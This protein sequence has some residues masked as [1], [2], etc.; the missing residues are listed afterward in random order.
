MLGVF[1]L[2]L[3][4]STSYVKI[5]DDR[6][7]IVSR[8]YGG[9]QLPQG[10]IIATDG[11]TG[12][13]AETIP[14][15]TFKVSLLYNVYNSVTTV[16]LV[17]VP[18]GYYGRIVARDGENLPEGQLM[19][20]AWPDKE[21]THYLDAQYFMTHHGQRGQQLSVLKPGTYPIN[22]ALFQVMIAYSTD[23]DDFYDE[24]GRT[25][26]RSG[27]D[28]SITRVPAGFVGVVRSSMQDTAK[29]CRTIT[30]SVDKDAPVVDK[31]KGSTDSLTAELVPQGCKGIWASALQPNDYFLNR[32]AYDVTLVD[33]RVQNLEF[34]GG[35]VRRFIDLKVGQD[36][37]FAQKER[38]VEVSVPEGAA[39]PAVNSKVEGWEVP[40]ELRVVV[41]I[42]PERAPIIVAA[43][44]G[45]KDVEK[46]IM[47]PSIRSQVRNV[48]GGMITTTVDG[49]TV[50]RQT[51]ILDLIE[52]REDLESTI[53]NLVAIDGRRAGAD[54]KEIK[55]G[56]P[57]IPPELLLARQREQLASQLLR[58]FQQEKLA[59]D[60][61]ITSEQ[62]KATAN[63][64]AIL[65]KAQIEVQTS[66]LYVT[67]RTNRGRADRKYAEEQAA[68]QKAQ[69]D[70][71]G[72]ERV[73]MLKAWDS[74]LQNPGIVEKLAGFHLPSTMVFG[75]GGLDG[76]AAQ[77]GN[78][79]LF[80]GPAKK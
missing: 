4:L 72:P 58:A 63:Q 3:V 17:R 11:E 33:T 59:Q 26:Q 44:G 67:E 51:R 1:V 32:E 25:Q 7:G 16:P 47:I 50:L 78:T 19:A 61:R 74:L 52:H 42:S 39:D 5:P 60:Q 54:V 55:L 48:L 20:S 18:N 28:T 34:K 23:K 57:V 56:E 75:A 36:G 13:Q 40:Q 76:L 71:L 41:Q 43:V 68:G 69:S 6:I 15:G 38:S 77:L 30:A 80:G 65:V 22:T 35:F 21:F 24:N 2:Y 8:V 73:A 79:S 45:L 12:Y 49:K 9:S 10:H 29:D 37:E 70:V 62:A 46:R 66:E 27:R 64:Q 31:V 53:L 14:P